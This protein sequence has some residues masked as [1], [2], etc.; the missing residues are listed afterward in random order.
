MTENE[1]KQPSSA[2][3]NWDKQDWR[4]PDRLLSE[5]IG[6]GLVDGVELKLT[7]VVHGQ[8]IVGTAI[9][10]QSWFKEQLDR[11]GVDPDTHQSEYGIF[12]RAMRDRA[13]E[14]QRVVE[15]PAE[16]DLTEEELA[17]LGDFT[18][19][20]HLKDAQIRL[21]VTDTVTYPAGVYMRVRLGSIDAWFSGSMEHKPQ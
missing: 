2:A 9:S 11:A 4:E 15:L 12:Y 13:A 14:L 17:T 10:G 18:H 7:L 8:V 5:M 3:R 21:P 1:Q 6:S 16:Q 20:L 19:M